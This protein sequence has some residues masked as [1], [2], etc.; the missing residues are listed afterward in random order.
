[1]NSWESGESEGTSYYTPSLHSGHPGDLEGPEITA[2]VV[3]IKQTRWLRGTREG[4]ILSE[5]GRA[6]NLKAL[7]YKQSMT[8]PD[9]RTFD[10]SEAN[11]YRS[12]GRWR[13]KLSQFAVCLNSSSRVSR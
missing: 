10:F 2:I 8:D 13:T 3:Q 5:T 11:F 7:T 6:A 1:M 9:I 4:M 12:G